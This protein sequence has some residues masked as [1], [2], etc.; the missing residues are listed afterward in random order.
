MTF[1]LFLKESQLKKIEVYTTD[2]GKEPFNERLLRH[3]ETIKAYIRKY[4]IRV[5]Q[6]GSKGNIRNL[7]DGVFEIKMPKA[8]GYRVYFG[9]VG[10]V[11][12]L[13]LLLGDKGSQKQDIIKA[14]EYW[15]NYNV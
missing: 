15:R 13:L 3:D 5:A 4:I 7:G 9:E 14:K 10:N 1:L 2:S 11:M 12:I 8:S 6:S